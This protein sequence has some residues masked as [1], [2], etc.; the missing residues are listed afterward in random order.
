MMNEAEQTT[1][2]SFMRK[3]V[4]PL[5]AGGLAGTLTSAGVLFYMDGAFGEA[6]SLSRQIAAAV[7]A[8]YMV[9]AI[10]VGVGAAS[11]ALGEKYLNTDDAD[12][13]REMRTVLMNSG[14]AMALWGAALLILALAAPDGPIATTIALATSV[15]LLAI[16]S[17]LGWRA[18]NASD[19]LF[20]AV[21][22]EATVWSYVGTVLIGGGCMVGAHLELM[23]A[24]APLDWLTLFYVVALA[25]SFI[26]SGRRGMLKIK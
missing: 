19:E 9:I 2:I 12:E 26:S 21:N 18:H 25:A 14:A 22:M 11:P 5:I 15:V 7:G 6:V 10:G 4:V 13:I 16:G 24:L 1:E 20:V 3:L 8:L 23:P 17:W